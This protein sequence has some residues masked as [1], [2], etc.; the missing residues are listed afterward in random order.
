MC[1]NHEPSA[2]GSF[3]CNYEVRVSGDDRLE[4]LRDWAE[5]R[6]ITFVQLKAELAKRFP[7]FDPAQWPD[8]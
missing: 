7:K 1:T 8:E 2:D 4:L 5:R 3:T 6:K